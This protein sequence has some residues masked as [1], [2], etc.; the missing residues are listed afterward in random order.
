MIAA[1]QRSECR[2]HVYRREIR[3]THQH[4]QSSALPRTKL[5]NSLTCKDVLL[6][7]NGAAA[8]GIGDSDLAMIDFFDPLQKLDTAGFLP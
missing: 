7:T 3:E 1:R 4:D 8:R 6:D 2:E 5:N